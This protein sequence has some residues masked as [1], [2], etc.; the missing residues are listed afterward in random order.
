MVEIR[1]NCVLPDF[2]HLQVGVRYALPDGLEAALVREGLAVTV[3]EPL[4]PPHV[5]ALAGPPAR[6]RRVAAEARA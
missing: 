5:Q 3:D 4:V 1:T 2:G 6:K